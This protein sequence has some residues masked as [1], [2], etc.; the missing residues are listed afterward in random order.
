[1]LAGCDEAPRQDRAQSALDDSSSHAAN[2]DTNASPGVR[3]RVGSLNE[4]AVVFLGTSLTA[5]YGLDPELAFPARIQE[6]IDAEGLPFRVV[7][8]GVSGETS[9]GGLRRID[10]VLREPTAAL[11]IEL[12][13]N[14]GL[15]G[16]DLS[17]M[18]HNLAAIIRR[19]RDLQP[20][21]D[22]LLAG[23]EAP[24]NL[25]R[26]YTDGFRETFQ[27]IA[28]DHGVALIPF[29]LEDVAGDLALNLDDRIHP[30]PAG[31]EIIA[32]TVWKT[33][34]PILRAR[35]IRASALRIGERCP[36]YCFPH[37]GVEIWLA[38]IRPS[39]T[40]RKATRRDRTRR[41]RALRSGKSC[42][43]PV[44]RAWRLLPDR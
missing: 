9:A 11:V 7:N 41:P 12:G 13:A 3:A 8:A 40:H 36:G 34:G 32:G 17:Q 35:A 26:Q 37:S 25:G 39:P 4:D 27:T 21:A 20:D 23:M 16:L 31:H 18:E 38:V 10:W 30:N 42:G 15:R 19:T 5:G 22:I 2:P 24:P 28:R 29:L 1:M 6:A 43:N 14:D 44:D 33:L